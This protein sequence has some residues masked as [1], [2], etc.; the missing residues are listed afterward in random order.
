MRAWNFEN[1]RYKIIKGT[2]QLLE[3]I[4][5]K[6]MKVEEKTNFGRLATIFQIC[7]IDTDILS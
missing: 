6:N 7:T 1:D 5:L 3:H 2:P 4:G